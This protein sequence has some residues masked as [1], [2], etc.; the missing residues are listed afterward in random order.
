MFQMMG[1]FAEFERAM[2]RERV[3]AGIARARSEGRPLGRKRLEETDAAKVTAIRTARAKGLELRRIATDLSVGERARGHERM[4]CH[5]RERGLCARP[6]TKG[7]EYVFS[8]SVAF[9]RLWNHSDANG[10]ERGAAMVH[11]HYAAANLHTLQAK[12]TV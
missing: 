11:T 3:L 4:S 9:H 5:G 1:V 8:P 12:G 7:A 6:A 10:R 2:I